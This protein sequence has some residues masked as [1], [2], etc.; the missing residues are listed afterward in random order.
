MHKK[1][2]PQDTQP[3]GLGTLISHPHL[4]LMIVAHFKLPDGCEQVINMP[5]V[6]HAEAQQVCNGIKH[7]LNAIH[8]DYYAAK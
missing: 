2:V 6:S 7:D 1:R 3:P 5:G 4:F 8:F